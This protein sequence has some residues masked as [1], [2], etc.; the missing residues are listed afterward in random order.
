[1]RQ[2][3]YYIFISTIL[4]YNLTHGQGPRP[5]IRVGITAALK[6]ENGSIGWAY[7]GGAVPL[8]LQ[9]L[10]SHGYMLNFDFE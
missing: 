4:T 10:K 6:T 7:T 3:N 5:V 8:A 9:Y 2:L 1:M